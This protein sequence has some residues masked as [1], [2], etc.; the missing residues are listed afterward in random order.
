MTD[1]TLRAA[2]PSALAGRTVM[3]WLVAAGAYLVL[4]PV[5]SRLLND[6]DVYTHLVVGRSILANRAF[7]HVDTFSATFA[8]EPWIAKEWLSQLIYTGAYSL[9]GWS[10]MAML[11]AAAT[12]AALGLLAHALLKKLEPLAAL[13]LTLAALVLAAP[14][15]VARPHA[16][17]LPLMVAWT[18]GLIR[19][20]DERRAPSFWLLPLMLAWANLHGGFTL[21]LALIA[22]FAIE[23][24]WQDRK[25]AQ[26]WIGFGVAAALTACITPYGPESI[27]VTHRILGLGDALD[28]VV[29]WRPQDFSRLAGFEVLLL[30]GIG[31]ALSRGV[32]LSPLRILV[33]LGLLHLALAHV[34]NAEI[35]GLLGPLLLGK[36][37][38]DARAAPPLPL[39]LRGVVLASLAAASVFFGTMHPVA[40][41][42][43]ITPSAALAAIEKAKAGPVLNDYGFGGYL[44]SQGVAPFIDGRTELYGGAFTARHHRAVTLA[45]LPDFL[46]LLDEYNIGATLLAPS[47]PAVALLD[48][49]PGWERLY[50]DNIAVVHVRKRP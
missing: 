27:L 6:A 12:A 45:N 11:A 10:A 17:A 49:L 42:A 39:M 25:T 14:H 4:L 40:P 36:P 47:R 30:G 1:Q 44:L 41:G 33:L 31:L 8:G 16:L 7:P 26:R 15:L 20:V 32:T 21:G 3:P 29:E 22:P 2:A 35:L 50:A 18:A 46:A 13:S 24:V 48:R 28:L 23:G 9:G 37:R 34:R 19:A 43:S 38:E 5:G